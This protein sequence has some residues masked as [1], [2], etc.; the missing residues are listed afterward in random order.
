MGVVLGGE[1]W[2]APITVLGRGVGVRPGQKRRRCYGESPGR[3]AETE[4]MVTKRALMGGGGQMSP[5]DFK[6]WQCPLSLILKCPC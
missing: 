5:V 2:D 6:K 3:Y 1:G 4:A